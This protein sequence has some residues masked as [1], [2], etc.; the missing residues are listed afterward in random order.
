MNEQDVACPKCGGKTWDNRATKRNPKAPD[1]KCRDKSCDGAV[2]PPKQG[3]STST[4][5]AQPYQSPSIGGYDG[6]GRDFLDRQAQHEQQTVSAIQMGAQ[7]GLYQQCLTI[8]CATLPKAC[9]DMGVSLTADALVAATATL[10]IQAC[11]G[12]AA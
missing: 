7:A 3:Q 5:S 10:Y 6:S 12:R 4:A 8:A 11:K 2:W 1:Y 9:E